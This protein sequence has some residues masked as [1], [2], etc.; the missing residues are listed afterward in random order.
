MT[1]ATLKG[2]S[3]TVSSVRCRASM[4]S[5]V[6]AWFAFLPTTFIAV[7]GWIQMGAEPIAFRFTAMTEESFARRMVRIACSLLIVL[8]ITTRAKEVGRVC[9]K[10]GLL[11]VLPAISVVSILWSQNP[12]HT[13]VNAINLTL[14]TL[15]AVYLY[16]RYTGEELISFLAFAAAGTLIMCAVS[17]VFVPSVGI[18]QLQ[19]GAWR[20][21][22][23]QKIN[24]AVIC[25]CY[26]LLALHYRARVL[27][28]QLVRCVVLVLAPLFI[29][30]SKS[31]TGW[32]LAAFALTL[33]LSLQVLRRFGRLDRIVVLMALA[34][35][36]GILSVILLGDS[37][38]LL[39]FMGKDPTMTQ[40][41]VI[42][43]QVIPS[44]AKHPLIGYGYSSF[45]SGLNSES[46]RTVLVTGWLQGQAQ[47]GYLDLLLQL[48]IAGFI[49]FLWMVARAFSQ[50]WRSI[51]Q[52]DSAR[53]FQLATALL[54]LILA[55]NIGETFI[56]LPLSLIWFYALLS[57]LILSSSNV[58]AEATA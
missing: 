46:I 16:I 36:A 15:F 23:S 6:S 29:V 33:T 43:S 3:G 10:S 37:T 41:T 28:E 7:G 21:I 55:S 56:L 31:R 45:W 5:E 26:L 24:C 53:Q 17:V 32:L 42:W 50:S 11:F 51:Q 27:L 48:G 34:V 19:D 12:G 25:V 18:D 54:P 57:F 35:P 2:N 39:S 1:L 4:L 47:D 30:M 14:T 40:R 9:L 58:S 8:L 52:R 22:F 44:I 20:G 13:L 49:P 38:Q